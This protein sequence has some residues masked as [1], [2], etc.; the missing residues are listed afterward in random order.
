MEVRIGKDNSY[1]GLF[2]KFANDTVNC[3]SLLPECM[4]IDNFLNEFCNVKSCL[5]NSL[6]SITEIHRGNIESFLDII[7]SCEN[8]VLWDNCWKNLIG[9]WS[10][11]RKYFL[12]K[13]NSR[14]YN[15]IS[16]QLKTISKIRPFDLPK[17]FEV[18]L[19]KCTDKFSFKC[20]PKVDLIQLIE[21]YLNISNDIKIFSNHT[22]FLSVWF[23]I[24]L[25]FNETTEVKRDKLYFIS[26]RVCKFVGN[27][28]T[29]V[30]EF[31]EDPDIKNFCDGGK[32]LIN[33]VFSGIKSISDVNNSYAKQ[34]LTNILSNDLLE[35]VKE[36]FKNDCSEKTDFFIYFTV[37]LFSNLTHILISMQQNVLL[38]KSLMIRCCQ[39]FLETTIEILKKTH[40]YESKMLIDHT[41]MP[42]LFSFLKLNLKDMDYLRKLTIKILHL[43]IKDEYFLNYKCQEL[44][45]VFPH[46]STLILDAKALN[47]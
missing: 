40:V 38:T 9:Y 17:F 30:D 21:L 46:A 19:S 31:L 34:L 20:I 23:C 12:D 22:Y 7:V 39:T 45:A 10:N 13:I 25:T 24:L 2:K 1:I 36:S 18:I 4:K 28:F 42:L 11:P 14:I 32:Y 37:E 16:L 5:E 15:T 35:I 43:V 29:S 3:M 6:V 8:L 44:S 33:Y 47:Y 26:T 41:I 27:E